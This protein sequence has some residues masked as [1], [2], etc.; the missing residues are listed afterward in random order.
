MVERDAE[1]PVDQRIEFRIGINLGDVIVEADDIYGDGVNV[2]ARLETL[3]EP[4][5]ILISGTA[6]DQVEGKFDHGFEYLGEQRLKNIAKPVRAYRVRTESGAAGTFITV[7]TQRTP[8]ARWLAVLAAGVIS[9]T[10]I[11]AAGWRFYLQPLLQERAFAEQT[12]LPVPD[13]PSIAVLPFNNMSDDPAQ[14]YFSDGMTEGQALALIPGTSRSGITMTVGLAMG[15]SREAAGRF[16]FLLA[17]PAIGMAA[18]KQLFDFARAPETVDWQALVPAMLISAATA[19]VVIAL[20]LRL[21]GKIGMGV[22]AIYRILL[23]VVIFY[24]LV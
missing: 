16:S 10:A 2:A 3:A 15:L 6:F 18:S 7:K 5:G 4:G 1:V 19:F 8:S 21:I 12:A 11:G 9:L 20:F 17:I 23:A 24:V 22:F 13:R 14:E